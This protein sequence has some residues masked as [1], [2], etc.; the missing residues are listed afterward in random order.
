VEGDG[1]ATVQDLEDGEALQ[2]DECAGGLGDF[3]LVDQVLLA[4]DGSESRR[5]RTVIRG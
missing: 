5:S 3:L 2:D 4:V 1:L